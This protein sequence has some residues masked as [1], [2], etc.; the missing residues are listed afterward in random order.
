MLLVI[1]K[2]DKCWFVGTRAGEKYPNQEVKSNE[3][4]TFK[5]ATC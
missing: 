4:C 5:S 1:E 3:D 2:D